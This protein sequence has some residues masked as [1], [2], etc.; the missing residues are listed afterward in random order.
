G[1]CSWTGSDFFDPDGV[2]DIVELLKADENPLRVSGGDILADVIG[3]DGKLSMAAIDEHGILNARRTSEGGDGVEC[4]AAGAAGK[5]DI[6]RED[7]GLVGQIRRK[8]SGLDG[9][10]LAPCAEMIAMHGDGEHSS[11]YG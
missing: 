5:E 4:G 9:K 7:E 8:M 2:R 6:I 3:A 1:E 11:L 10:N